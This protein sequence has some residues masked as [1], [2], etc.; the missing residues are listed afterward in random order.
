LLVVETLVP[1]VLR[2]VSDIIVFFVVVVVRRWSVVCLALL[3]LLLLRPE[4]GLIVLCLLDVVERLGGTFSSC[5][6]SA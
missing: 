1:L 2:P 6:S 5:S 3:L 4:L